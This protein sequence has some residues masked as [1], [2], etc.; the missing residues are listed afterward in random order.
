MGY[1]SDVRLTTT[2]KGWERLKEEAGDNYLIEYADELADSKNIIYLGWNDVKWYSEGDDLVKLMR[3]LNEKEG[4]PYGFMRIG[5]SEED[6]EYED[7][8][9]EYD[10]PRPYM[11]RK[12]DDKYIEEELFALK[13]VG[14]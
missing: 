6:V 4:H 7:I 3:E 11:I 2:K 8:M 5:E 9:E 13:K 12:P 10:I 14:E 1:Y